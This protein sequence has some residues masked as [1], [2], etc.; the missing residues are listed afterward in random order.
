MVKA[1]SGISAS[2]ENKG[3]LKRNED[4]TS[5]WNNVADTESLAAIAK[6]LQD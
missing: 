2:L 1:Q 6:C 4:K 5:V 3:F